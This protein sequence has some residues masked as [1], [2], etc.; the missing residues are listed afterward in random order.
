MKEEVMAERVP[1]AEQ[2]VANGVTATPW[3]KAL[4]RLENPEKYRTY[5]LATVRAGGRPHVM[6]LLGLWLDGAFY[7]VTGETT[8][9]GR[10]LA[11]NPNCVVTFGSQTLPALDLMIEGKA[12]RVTDEAELR[13]VAEAYASKMGWPLEVRDGAVYGPNAPT[14]GSSPYA[15][16]ELTPTTVFGLPASPGRMKKAA[17]SAHSAPPAGVSSAACAWRCSEGI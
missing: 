11:G 14:A 4:E 6:P 9:K 3:A 10:N 16:F 13:R 7:F 17:S 5:W 15:V 12:T 1:V 2:P 8:R